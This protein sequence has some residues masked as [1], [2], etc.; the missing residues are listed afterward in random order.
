VF[1]KEPLEKLRGLPGDT[2]V[3]CGHEYTEKN[4]E[5]ARSIEPENERIR[6]R[7]QEV[8]ELRAKSQFTVPGKMADELAT[9]PFLRWESAELQKT[10]GVGTDAVAV[11]ARTREL[12][13]NF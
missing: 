7:L 6:G 11:F 5:F 10:L 3:Y 9:N 12:K 4:L 2:L 13:D 1:S 8:R